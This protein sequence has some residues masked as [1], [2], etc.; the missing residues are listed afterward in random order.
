MKLFL[1]LLI[2]FSSSTFAMNVEQEKKILETKESIA[3][4][5]AIDQCARYELMDLIKAGYKLSELKYFLKNIEQIDKKNSQEIRRIL[6]TWGWPGKTLFG[7][8]TAKNFWL[9]VQHADLSPD[10]QTTALK[11]I[12]QKRNTPDSDPKSYAYLWDR[13]K[14]HQNLPQRYGTQGRCTGKH[15]WEP[16][17]LEDTVHVNQLRSAVGLESL[18]KYQKLIS[19]FC[20]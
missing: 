19:D 10:I 11:L 14:T 20:P 4:M 1:M 9:L 15:K 7:D 3:A 13:I 12:E 6:S 5:V 18:E 8:L 17:T 2:I 16:F